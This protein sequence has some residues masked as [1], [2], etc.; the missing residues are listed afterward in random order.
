MKNKII[1]M[2]AV[3]VVLLTAC[4]KNTFRTTERSFEDG[5]A[6]IKL[7]LFNAPT[8]ATALLAYINGER[9]S[10]SLLLPYP[11]PGGG[12][13]TGG[14]SNGDYLSVDPG[15]N[16]LQLFTTN[17]GTANVI[18]EFQKADLTF[19]A[20][21]KYTVYTTDTAEN[22]VAITTPDDAT[23]PDSGYSRIRF[24]HLMPNV[25]AVD[26]YKGNTL[27]KSNIAYKAYT[28]FFDVAFGADSF[29]IRVAGAPA[30]SALSALAYRVITPTNKRIYSFLSRGYQGAT[31]LRAP[32]V[33]AI[34]NQ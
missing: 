10:S 32:N 14:S 33:S 20:N 28:D 29:S 3:V 22:A 1:Y 16:K 13:N 24:I 7:G 27:L 15:A 2:F 6:Q 18:R 21:K 11:F 5:K 23:A 4:E 31:L 12:F 25:P 19:E 30:G 8:A 9:V 17:P 26:F 34:V